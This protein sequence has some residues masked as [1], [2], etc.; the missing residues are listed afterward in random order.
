MILA[1]WSDKGGTGKSTLATTT[2]KTLGFPVYDLDPQGDATRWCKRAAHP[3]TS[4]ANEPWEAVKLALDRIATSA[5]PVV[6][7]CPPGHDPRSLSGAALARLA[8]L[9]A[10]DGDS[11]L[12][13]LGRGLEY[14]KRLRGSGN[15]DLMVAVALNKVNPNTTLA[16]QAIQG[17]RGASSAKGYHFLGAVANRISIRQSFGLGTSAISAGGTAAHEMRTVVE[18]IRDILSSEVQQ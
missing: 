11:D 4:L 8:V 9:V 14:L 5:T 1:F 7:D 17:L 10:G 15:P 2:A 16:K 3:C 6:V 13:A 12:V 18:A